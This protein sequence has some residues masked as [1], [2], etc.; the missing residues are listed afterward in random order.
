M[1]IE[2][3]EP[4]SGLQTCP[5]CLRTT[6]PPGALCPYC[7]SAYPDPGAG[8]LAAV[9]GVVAAVGIGFALAVQG[10]SESLAGVF[11]LVG[12]G[13]LIGAIAMGAR[14]RGRVGPVHHRQVSCCGC[15]C[16]VALLVLPSA[17]ALLWM[18]GG[19]AMAALALPAWVPLSWAV[20]AC[21][22]LAVRCR[23]RLAA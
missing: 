18:H 15:S 5:G 14:V 19:P 6:G 8:E 13:A 12:I 1:V 7:G 4:A 22:C 23:R 16:A 21:E 17:G 2:P 9:L 3:Q 11:A 20:H 10:L